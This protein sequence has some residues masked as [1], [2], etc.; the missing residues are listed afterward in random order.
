MLW[1]IKIGLN[2]RQQRHRRRAEWR[3]HG[4]NS[5]IADYI[6]GGHENARRN[7]VQQNA[8]FLSN[9]NAHTLQP[10]LLVNG[11]HRC[12]VAI[13]WILAIYKTS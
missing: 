1:N 5:Y 6:E 10:H 3:I 12:C 9:G 13:R 7:C 11:E 2:W 8:K 4:R